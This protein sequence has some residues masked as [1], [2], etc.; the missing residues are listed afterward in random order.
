MATQTIERPDIDERTEQDDD[1]PKVFHYVK[2]DK[3]A[4]SA[5]MGTH[6]VALCGETFPVTKAAKPGSP[7]CEKCKK[8]Y[9]KMKK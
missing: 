7:V 8:V 9:E 6:V 5:V 1:T 4:E 3:M 2:K